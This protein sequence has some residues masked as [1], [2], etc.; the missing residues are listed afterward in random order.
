[1]EE[2]IY[3]VC[4]VDKAKLLVKNNFLPISLLLFD[5]SLLRIMKPNL[6][7]A[8]AIKQDMKDRFLLQLLTKCAQWF[9]G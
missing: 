1:M 8:V 2:K 3:A 5:L 4:L 7:I 9:S 6:P